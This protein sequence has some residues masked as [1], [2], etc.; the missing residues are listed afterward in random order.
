MP[1]ARKIDKDI[2]KDFL[3]Q[4]K[5]NLKKSPVVV[6]EEPPVLRQAQEPQNELQRSQASPTTM[7]PEALEGPQSPTSTMQTTRGPSTGSGTA[8]TAGTPITNI[9]PVKTDKYADVMNIR[10][11]KGRRNEIK[12]FCSSNGV[13][14]T[15]YI[16]SSF[17]FLSREVAAGNISLSKGGITKKQI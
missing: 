1:I 13:T 14:V 10:L 16:E 15:Q 8:V 2:P 17:E 3:N 9:L 11:S 5:T 6:E 4:M 7:V 12:A